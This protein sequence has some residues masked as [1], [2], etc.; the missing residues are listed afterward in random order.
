MT[1]GQ[2]ILFP[3]RQENTQLTSDTNDH[4]HLRYAAF[5]TG[6]RVYAFSTPRDYNEQVSVIEIKANASPKEGDYRRSRTNRAEAFTHASRARE[7]A[8][9]HSPVSRTHLEAEKLKPYRTHTN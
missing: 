2:N 1:G 6:V 8:C 4:T 9:A 3:Y 7:L 5:E